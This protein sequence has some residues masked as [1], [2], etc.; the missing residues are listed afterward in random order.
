[1]ADALR[2]RDLTDGSLS[3][4]LI[5]LWAPMTWG[6]AMVM[7]VALVD[8]FFIGQ[9]GEQPLTALGFAFPMQMVLT[10]L[11]IGL[12]AAAT[13]LVSKARGR[14]EAEL[15]KRHARNVLGVAVGV[16]TAVAL[17]GAIAAPAIFRLQGASG[18]SLELVTG[19]MRLWLIGLPFLV[20]GIVSNGIMRAEGESSRAAVVMTTTAI[21]NAMLDPLFIFGFGP[22]PELGL[23]GAAYASIGARLAMAAI[24]VWFLMRDGRSIATDLKLGSSDRFAEIGQIAAPAAAS[25]M[26]NPLGL[27]ALTAALALISEQ[28]VAAFGVGSRVLN[29]AQVPLLGLSAAIGPLIGQNY[30]AD[31]NDRVRGA[32]MLCLK[33]IAGY[34]LILAIGLGAFG[35]QLTALFT[36]SQTIADQAA[37][38][39]LI[40]PASVLGYGALIVV[41][42]ALNAAGRPLP[43]TIAASF[44]MFIV[45]VPLAF[46]AAY[47]FDVWAVYAALAVGNIMGGAAALYAARHE[48]LL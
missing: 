34:T 30:G 44:R 12:S 45:T 15:A 29:F 21:V 35:G 10:S 46:I 16:A 13:S 47:L 28:A 26:I 14:D 1:M 2:E 6:V 25:N 19:F 37:L 4:H 39:L 23:D 40:V 17:A 32:L 42:G 3:N 18:E 33:I 7:S 41:I 43:G 48:G 36:D 38:F 5:R 22:V 24:A 31:L 8:T 9:Y 27:A 11:G 20:F